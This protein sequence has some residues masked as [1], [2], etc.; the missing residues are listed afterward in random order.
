VQSEYLWTRELSGISV[1]WELV[2]DMRDRRRHWTE[3]LAWS[4]TDASDAARSA[5]RLLLRAWSKDVPAYEWLAAPAL[6]LSALRDCFSLSA[7]G[8]L[9][10]QQLIWLLLASA[11]ARRLVAAKDFASLCDDE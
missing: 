9:S 7:V 2:R 6:A 11:R 3:M 10:E 5:C 4:T 8:L 1:L